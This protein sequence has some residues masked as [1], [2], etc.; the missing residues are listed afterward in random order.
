MDIIMEDYIFKPTSR[1]SNTETNNNNEIIEYYTIKD[2]ES[3]LDERGFPRL[4]KDGDE[5]YAKRFLRKNGTTKY[6]VRLDSKSK[7]YNPISIYGKENDKNFLD[8]VCRSDNKFTE[9]NGKVFDMYITFL[10]TGNVSYLYNAERE[11]E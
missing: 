8:R 9:V 7:L 6:T 4:E 11:S 3:Y 5:V 1:Y 2:S 10:R